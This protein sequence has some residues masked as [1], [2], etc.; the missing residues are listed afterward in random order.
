LVA[1]DVG[2]IDAIRSSA[3]LLKR[4][5]GEQVAGNVGLGL[6][7]A[8]AFFLLIVLSIP[9][10]IL[11]A[12]TG[13]PIVVV[14]AIGICVLA[15]ILLS[16]VQAALSGIYS[17]ALYQFA[18]TGDAGETFPGALVQQAFKPR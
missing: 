15:L 17:A 8:L 6:A 18:T 5:W 16:L 10:V 11:A 1:Q 7:F 3:G 2:P 13:E 9:V 14:L 4:T 12:Q